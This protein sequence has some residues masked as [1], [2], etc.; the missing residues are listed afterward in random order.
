MV[1]KELTSKIEAEPVS[2]LTVE[3]QRL[4]SLLSD[5]LHKRR[6]ELLEDNTSG[7]DSSSRRSSRGKS[8][9]EAALDQRREELEMRQRELEDAVRNADKIE[10]RLGDLR[11]DDRSE[12][13]FEHLKSQDAKNSQALES[14][15]QQAEKLLN[16]VS[17]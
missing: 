9:S 1:Q 13:E 16:K 14:A 15:Q 11:L 17:F 8:S 6:K 7:D 10:S 3:R 12:K 5:N 4:E 2:R